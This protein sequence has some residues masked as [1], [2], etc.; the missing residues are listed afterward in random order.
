MHAYLHRHSNALENHCHCQMSRSLYGNISTALTEARKAKSN[1]TKAKNLVKI[2]AVCAAYLMS[3]AFS[4]NLEIWTAQLLDA[5]TVLH[6]AS[7]NNF[8][9]DKNQNYVWFQFMPISICWKKVSTNMFNKFPCFFIKNLPLHVKLA[10][11]ADQDTNCEYCLHFVWLALCK[12]CSD[13]KDKPQVMNIRCG[14][15]LWPPVS[16]WLAGHTTPS[17]NTNT[18]VIPPLG[19][20]LL[21]FSPRRVFKCSKV[22][23][24]ND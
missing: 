19:L 24:L 14:N 21:D 2:R 7:P 10:Q 23:K 20:P 16:G 15:A 1:S 12:F 3:I 11:I 13:V 9:H 6:V 18:C 8:W 22:C 17:G 4:K 5:A